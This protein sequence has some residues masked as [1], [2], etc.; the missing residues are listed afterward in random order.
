VPRRFRRPGLARRGRRRVRGGR[1][2]LRRC[3]LSRTCA[4]RAR[5]C[6]RRRFHL[7]GDREPARSYG[8]QAVPDRGPGLSFLVLT[9]LLRAAAPRK[10]G[11]ARR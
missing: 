7:A 3:A 10:R 2:F 4:S 5:R 1:Q 8:C 11:P 9:L 6:L